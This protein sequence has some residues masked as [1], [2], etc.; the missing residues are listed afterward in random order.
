MGISKHE[1]RSGARRK[2]LSMVILLAV[3][4][5]CG[6]STSDN[7]TTIATQDGSTTVG[8][9][10]TPTE[11]TAATEDSGGEGLDIAGISF[12]TTA[13]AGFNFLGVTAVEEIGVENDVRTS[14]SERVEVADSARVAREFIADGFDIVLFHG[15]VYLPIAEELAAESPE[16]VFISHGSGPLENPVEN[17][18]HIGRAPAYNS[19]FYL[20]G[21]LAGKVTTTGT[22]AFLG[23]IDFPD[24]IAAVNS[25]FLG[26]Q[27]ANP[28]VTLLHTFTGEW[29]DPVIGR[30]AAEALI[31]QGADVI[32]PF[33]DQ[34]IAGIA[35]A[36]TE[37][38]VPVFF[39]AQ[40][41]EKPDLAPDHY[42]TSAVW[43][44]SNTLTEIYDEIGAGTRD[45]YIEISPVTGGTSLGAVYNV[46]ADVEEEVQS[47]FDAFASGEREIPAPP[48][49]VIDD[50]SD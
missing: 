7:T 9:S 4:A 19:G 21:Y 38:A 43:E 26:A 49:D 10:T 31:A 32:V 45:G 41:T 20:N 1:Y 25:F 30:Q 44:F 15:G 48:N 34:A 29:D 8:A 35:E 5:A 16:T 2:A 6:G 18:W 47:I 3:L 13:D 33:V 14:F 37:A 27:D 46:P 22:V 28:D 39:T 36:A 24:A 11:T 23:A 12:G 17:R 40:Y 42:L 50:L